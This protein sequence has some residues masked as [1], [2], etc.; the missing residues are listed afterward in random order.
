M[1]KKYCLILA[2]LVCTVVFV[3][4]CF[5]SSNNV[6]N[7]TEN[8]GNIIDDNITGG[9]ITND[10]YNNG[11]YYCQDGNHSFFDWTVDKSPTCT[12][13]KSVV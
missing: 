11:V 7:D 8:S 12:D 1:K 10:D 4:S 13:R 2:I 9:D 3:T 6:N 5:G